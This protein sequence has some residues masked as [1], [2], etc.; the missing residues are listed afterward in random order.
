ML[1]THLKF[2]MLIIVLVVFQTVLVLPPVT[3]AL[4]T[5][6]LQFVWMEK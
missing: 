3:V 6:V 5:Y 1:L 2:V 4:I